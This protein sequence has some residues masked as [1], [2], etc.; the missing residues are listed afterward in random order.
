LVANLELAA[1]RVEL[2]DVGGR[3]LIRARRCI[4][5]QDRADRLLG[6]VGDG[7]DELRA[8][9]APPLNLRSITAPPSNLKR[10]R[11]FSRLSVRL[12]VASVM[13]PSVSGS[14]Q[15]FRGNSKSYSS[16]AKRITSSSSRRGLGRTR[17]SAST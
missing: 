11:A 17:N 16:V 14:V 5:V 15:N 7:A 2:V 12:R 1:V 3:D 4:R 9:R 10:L 13:G 8:H 6:D